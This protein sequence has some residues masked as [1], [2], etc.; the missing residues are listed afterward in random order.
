MRAVD[1]QLRTLTDFILHNGDDN[2]LFVLIG[3]HQPPRVS[4]K[5]DGWATPVHIIS[6]DGTLIKDFAD[7]GF[8]PGLQVQSYETELHHEGIYSML[9]RVLLKRYG[10]DPSA[11]PAYLPQGV[12]AEEVAVNGQ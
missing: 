8:V 4:R 11:L 2:S 12:N 3:D 9:M 6:K 7:Y 10:S 1:Y 5:S